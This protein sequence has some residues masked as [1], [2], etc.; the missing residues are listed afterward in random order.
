[1]ILYFSGTGNSEYVAKRIG[2]ETGDDSLDLLGKIRSRD[3]WEMRSDRPWVVVAPTYAWRIP[4]IVQEWLES[5]PLAGNRDIYFVMTCGGDIGNAGRYLKK[6]CAV[7]K[8]DYRGCAAIVMPENYIAMFSVPTQEEAQ[9]IIRQAE[10]VIDEAAR[11][12]KGGEI[13]SQPGLGFKD[14]MNSGIVNDIFYPLFVHAKKFYADDSCISCGKCVRVC[15]LNNI[16]LEK[17]RP[18][19]GKNCTHCMAC[20]CRCPSEAIEYGTHSRGKRRYVCPAS[21]PPLKP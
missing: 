16:R 13:F 6:L 1:M 9:R 5:T 18:L 21:V 14:K 3:H 8:M 15:P 19:W 10:G 12:I 4:R 20:I 7:K 17:G 2:R 11:R